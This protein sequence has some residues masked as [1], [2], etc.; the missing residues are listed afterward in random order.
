MSWIDKKR[1]A[2]QLKIEQNR[3][4]KRRHPICCFFFFF[5]PFM[6]KKKKKN[7]KQKR[8]AFE[9][10]FGFLILLVHVWILSKAD[11]NFLKSSGHIFSK[12][13]IFICW[14]FSFDWQLHVGE[15]EFQ[16]EKLFMILFWVKRFFQQINTV[17]ISLQSLFCVALV[18]LFEK[19]SKQQVKT[20]KTWGSKNE[21]NK[22]QEITK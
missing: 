22:V 6:A 15:K 1:L 11:C 17:L 19:K 8:K 21:K 12:G 2:D 3:D 13:V 14:Q 9:V 10:C 16:T 4:F 20:W 7:Q 5:K 18:C